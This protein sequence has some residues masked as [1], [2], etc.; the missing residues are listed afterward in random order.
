MDGLAASAFCFALVGV[1]AL[2]KTRK[3]YKNPERKGSS[4]T[5]L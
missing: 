5:G 1:V 4:R 2:V 3:T